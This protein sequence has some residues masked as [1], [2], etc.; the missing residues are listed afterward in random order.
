MM[1]GENISSGRRPFSINTCLTI[2]RTWICLGLN[3]VPGIEPWHPLSETNDL[4]QE[5][6]SGTEN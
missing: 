6:R 2:N 5:E 4:P 3:P 1:A